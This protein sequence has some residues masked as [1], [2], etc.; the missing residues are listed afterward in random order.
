MDKMDSPKNLH[1]IC[2]L[3]VYLRKKGSENV[4]KTKKKL[5]LMTVYYSYHLTGN[6][7]ILEKEQ[8]GAG[9]WYITHACTHRFKE[10]A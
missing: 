3:C 6:P 1:L 5:L 7:H 4:E 9:F 2:Q 10:L 8:R